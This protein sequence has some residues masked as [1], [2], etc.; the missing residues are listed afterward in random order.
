MTTFNFGN[1]SSALS[2]VEESGVSFEGKAQKWESRE[3]GKLP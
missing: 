1:F 3:A 2:S